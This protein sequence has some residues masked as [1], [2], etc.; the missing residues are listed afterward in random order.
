MFVNNTSIVHNTTII[1]VL[2][3]TSHH[4]IVQVA[5]TYKAEPQSKYQPPPKASGFHA[6]NFHSDKVEWDSLTEKLLSID[7]TENFK[8]RTEDEKLSFIYNETCKMQ[9]SLF[10]RRRRQKRSMQAEYSATERPLL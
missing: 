2:Q 3:S 6:L 9:L 8:D 4:S 1:P 10:Q 7:W 5:T